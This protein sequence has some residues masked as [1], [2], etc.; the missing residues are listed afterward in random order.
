[1]LSKP[2]I[3]NKLK[4]C[5]TELLKFGVTKIGLFG[6]MKRGDSNVKSDIDILIDFDSENETYD[7]YIN[8]C[9]FLESLFKNTKLDIVSVN[10][11]SPFIGLY[12]IKEV[13]YA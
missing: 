11:L 1:M 8:T 3:L 4:S 7:N 12:I 13:E 6:S 9:F 2:E 5:K 10:G